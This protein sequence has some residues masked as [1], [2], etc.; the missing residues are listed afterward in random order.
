MLIVIVCCRQFL[1]FSIR[2]N[3]QTSAQNLNSLLDR[4]TSPSSMS[5]LFLFLPFSVSL[6][7][8][9]L[10]RTRL[11]ALSVC[12]CAKCLWDMR[13]RSLQTL[14]ANK[15]NPTQAAAAQHTLK[16]LWL[17]HSRKPQSRS[18]S[19]SGADAKNAHSTL[20]LSDSDYTLQSSASFWTPF[21]AVVAVVDGAAHAKRRASVHL[22]A[23]KQ[24]HRCKAQGFS[25]QSTQIALSVFCCDGATQ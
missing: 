18:I 15:T 17:T 5:T 23:S 14:Q 19:D 9:A 4:Q 10:Y 12:V 1:E 7:V 3:A 25:P 20:K 11:V 16:F 8:A 24:Q 13:T 6:C 2:R 21:G 22:F